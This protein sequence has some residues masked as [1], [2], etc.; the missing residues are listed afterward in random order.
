[1]GIAGRTA[2][3]QDLKTTSVELAL[4][5]NPTLP[6]GL[7]GEPEPPL[8]N[9]QVN[10]LL[11]GLQKKNEREAIQTAVR[12]KEKVYL[13]DTSEVTHVLVKKGKPPPLG[14]QYDSPFPITDRIGDNCIRI[15]VGTTVSGEPRL[16]LQH[17]N[18]CRPAVITSPDQEEQRP[19]PGRKANLEPAPDWREKPK[20]KENEQDTEKGTVVPKQNEREYK[21]TRPQRVRNKPI[22]YSY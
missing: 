9:D 14:A 18:N 7:I 6:G 12:T 15:K 11:Q 5:L 20:E 10:Q 13:P 17:W 16:E 21:S 19:R 22:R 3:Q 8:E 2:Y 1:M 4:G